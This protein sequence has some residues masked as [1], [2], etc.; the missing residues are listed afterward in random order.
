ME[1]VLKLRTRKSCGPGNRAVDRLRSEVQSWCETS[2]GGRL[3]WGSS[4][5]R[6]WIPNN[7]YEYGER[8]F[9]QR[10]WG[11]IWQVHKNKQIYYI[12]INILDGV[13]NH[14]KG[15]SSVK[16][17]CSIL[18]SQVGFTENVAFGGA[19]VAQLVKCQTLDLGSDH[20]VTVR[21]FKP[22]AELCMDSTEPAWNF[23][24]SLSVPPFHPK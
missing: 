15:L 24:P 18:N 22:Y 7:V 14:K 2:L 21:E 17:G 20:D 6:W 9:I 19:W 5:G 13:I 1:E 4:S 12:K 3:W 10:I 8:R 11:W 16:I 23:S